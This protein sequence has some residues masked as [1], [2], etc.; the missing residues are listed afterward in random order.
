MKF[1]DGNYENFQVVARVSTNIR[2]AIR[3]DWNRLFIGATSAKVYDRFYV[4]RCYHCNEF[5]HYA[6]G[7]T[8]VKS[9]GICSAENDHE[10]KDCPHRTETGTTHLSCINCKK[11]GG[12]GGTSH[13]GH[14]ASSPKCPAY[15][16]AQ[17]KLRGNT[18]YY[19]EKN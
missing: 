18:P 3:S 15:K 17:K 4:K 16:L 2:D 5:G 19:Q 1:P 11:A 6:T 13:R 8:R 10:S 7:C 12:A 9:C 14:A